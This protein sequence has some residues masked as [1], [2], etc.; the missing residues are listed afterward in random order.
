MIPL[1]V[2]IVM[3]G[4]MAAAS[5]MARADLLERDKRDRPIALEHY[6]KELGCQ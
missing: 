2:A 3:A 4:G 5:L 1:A 6:R